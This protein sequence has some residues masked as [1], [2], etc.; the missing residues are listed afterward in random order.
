MKV[1]VAHHL[2]AAGTL[3]AALLPQT[4]EHVLE[5]R[6]QVPHLRLG[7]VTRHVAREG[8]LGLETVHAVLPLALQL[9]LLVAEELLPLEVGH[10]VAGPRLLEHH[11][12]VR[13]AGVHLHQRALVAGG[14]HGEGEGLV[15]VLLIL[16]PLRQHAET[17]HGRSVAA[18][19]GAGLRGLLVL[20]QVE[21]VNIYHRG[22]RHFALS[23]ALRYKLSVS[24]IVFSPIGLEG[25]EVVNES[26]FV[27]AYD[28]YYLLS[29]FL[30]AG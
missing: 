30:L 24:V 29:L 28:N 15:L 16:A 9:Q 14:G 5:R 6:L 10:G 4:T 25:G 19:A 12:I 1:D 23:F 20:G 3:E 7:H 2:L 11:D 17:E 21:W 26:S 8:S 22:Q 18:G 13:A 27:L